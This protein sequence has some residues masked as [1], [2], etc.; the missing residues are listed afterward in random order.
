MGND[1]S[2]RVNTSQQ[3]QNNINNNFPMQGTKRKVY[4]LHNICLYSNTTLQKT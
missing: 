2:K 4:T 3:L 1:S